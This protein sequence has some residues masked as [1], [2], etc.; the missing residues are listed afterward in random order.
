MSDVSWPEVYNSLLA[1]VLRSARPDDPSAFRRL[2]GA[3]GQLGGVTAACFLVYRTPDEAA[4]SVQRFLFHTAPILLQQLSRT[5]QPQRVVLHG[6]I[7]GK[8]DWSGTYKARYSEDTNPTV[9]V[10]LQSWRRFD[11]PENQLFK[12]LLH[13]IQLC[14]ERVPHDLK[15]WRAWGQA[16]CPVQGAPLHLGDYFATLAHRVRTFSTHVYLQE[17]ELPATIGAQHLLAARTSKNELYAAVADLYDLYQ[18]VVDAPDWERWAAVLGQTLPLPPT[19]DEVGRLLAAPNE[20]A[21]R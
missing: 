4:P 8:V 1:Y 18:A 5:T 17:V 21:L 9:F 15:G 12:F 14:L 13:R 16:V 3:R 19:A 20:P 2:A 11:R 7:R 10:C 6:R